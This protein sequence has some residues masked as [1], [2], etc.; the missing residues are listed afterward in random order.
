MIPDDVAWTFVGWAYGV[1][2]V[3]LALYGASLWARRPRG[4]GASGGAR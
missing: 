3:S 1:T 2:W 4:L